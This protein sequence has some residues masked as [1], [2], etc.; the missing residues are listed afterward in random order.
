MLQLLSFR[1]EQI[2]WRGQGSVC[3]P[4]KATSRGHR[5]VRPRDFRVALAVRS[6]RR[7]NRASR[8]VD[9]T[10]PMLRRPSYVGYVTHMSGPVIGRHVGRHRSR[11]HPSAAVVVVVTVRAIVEPVSRVIDARWRRMNDHR[12]RRRWRRFDDDRGSRRVNGTASRAEACQPGQ[13]NNHTQCQ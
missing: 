11:D 5:R 9:D 3:G 12:C 4:W 6:A 10:R 13:K 1:V 7:M 8:V 2:E